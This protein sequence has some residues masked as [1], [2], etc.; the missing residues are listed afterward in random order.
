M[1]VVPVVHNIIIHIFMGKRHYSVKSPLKILIK[2]IYELKL[3]S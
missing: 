3:N 1:H 2:P